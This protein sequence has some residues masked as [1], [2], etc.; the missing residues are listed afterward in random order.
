MKLHNISAWYHITI[1][2]PGCVCPT[3]QPTCHQPSHPG[4]PPPQHQHPELPLLARLEYW[5]V[6]HLTVM[7]VC[8]IAYSIYGKCL[9][10][11]VQENKGATRGSDRAGEIVTSVNS[12]SKKTRG[13]VF[14]YDCTS[15]QTLLLSIVLACAVYTDVYDAL[16]IHSSVGHVP[17]HSYHHH[18]ENFIQLP[19][20]PTHQPT[21]HQPS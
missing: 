14:H 17:P 18:P 11:F 13:S 1:R 8:Y 10:L 15:L 5:E 4:Y 2:P 20:G 6:C 12:T 21:Y 7:Q 9:N 16:S 3:H 19:V